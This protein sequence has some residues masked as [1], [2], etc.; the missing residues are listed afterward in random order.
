MKDLSKDVIRKLNVRLAAD[1][2]A[3]NH[4]YELF[5]IKHAFDRSMSIFELFFDTP[6]KLF[7]D[8]LEALQLYDLVELLLE[9]PRKPRPGRSL[10]AALS[11]QEIE[12]LRKTADP[13]PTTYHSTAAVLIITDEKNHLTEGI[14]R[15]FKGFSSKSD[16][17]VFEWKTQAYHGAQSELVKGR[18]LPA[19]SWLTRHIPLNEPDLRRKQQEAQ[20]EMETNATAVSAVIE[21]WIHNQGW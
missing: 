3:S 18:V 9:K 21:R 10:R 17:T 8:V 4:I 19:P 5:G 13:R 20:K 7:E 11:L 1:Q 6:V 15:F 12:K 16:V 2:V 14:E